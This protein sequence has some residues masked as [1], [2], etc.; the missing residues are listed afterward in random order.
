[1]YVCVCVSV[2][3]YGCE[4]RCVCA[5]VCLSLFMSVCKVCVGVCRCVSVYTGNKRHKKMLKEQPKDRPVC[6]STVW[7]Q[8]D[9][10]GTNIRQACLALDQRMLHRKCRPPCTCFALSCCNSC[11]ASWRETATLASTVGTPP[12][13]HTRT[14]THTHTHTITHKGTLLRSHLKQVYQ[15]FINENVRE[16]LT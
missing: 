15:V 13:K 9:S 3:A 6:V 11:E 10:L 8:F 5:Y 16:L 4:R 2:F 12:H 7:S 14:H 1:M